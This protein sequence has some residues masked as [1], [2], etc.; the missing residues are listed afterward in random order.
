M[1]L[2]LYTSKTHRKGSRP[3]RIRIRGDDAANSN[4]SPYEY[5][6][7]YMTKRGGYRSVSEPLFIFAD[8]RAVKPSHFRQVLREILAIM[9]LD[10]KLYDTHSFRIGRA[11]DLMKKGKSIKEIKHLGRWKSN[12]V[13]RY[14][15]Y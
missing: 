14:L 12:A 5:L 4:Y 9:N 11:M 15:K 2:V 8:G 10:S 1:L 7:R 6:D 3:Q 13:Y